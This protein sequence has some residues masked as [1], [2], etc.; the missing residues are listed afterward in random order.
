VK[1]KP[2]WEKTKQKYMEYWA[3]EN[4]RHFIW[5][6]APKE[7]AKYKS[8]TAPENPVD[9]WTDT[10]Y[11]IKKARATF[12]TT[13]YGGA[14][15]PNFCPNLGP[16]LLAAA[17][18]WC[19]LNFVDDNTG[20]P[21]EKLHDWKDAGKLELDVNNKWWKKIVEITEEAVRDSNGDY[22]VSITDLH[23]GLDAL[24]AIRGS[25]NLAIDLIDNPDQVKK[26]NFEIFEVFKQIVD[27]LYNITTKNI[28]GSSSWIHIWHPGKWYVTSCDFICMISPE[29][30]DEFVLPELK[31]ELF[32]L[33]ASIFHLDGPG[34]IKH[35]DALLEIPELKGVQWVYGAGQPSASH[36]IPL[37]KK[38]QDAGKLV[39]V[40][41][42]PAELD[43]LMEELRPE[44]VMLA[45]WVGSE[46]EARYLLKKAENYRP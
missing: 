13:F 41:F 33:D 31:E 18:G 4:E 44:G 17:T 24:A 8:I 6:C 28:P 21:S 46:E 26:A 45:T 16:N 7:G 10:E 11:L 20:W 29:M 23:P 38:I 9:R 32:W 15:F 19:E 22:F 34:A 40:Y 5:V 12:E 39:H 27:T 35:L 1:Y 3:R 2:D 25:E 36:W 14:A 30:F 43:I 37:L 42:D